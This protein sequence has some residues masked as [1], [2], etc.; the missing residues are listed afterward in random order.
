[1]SRRRPHPRAAWVAAAVLPVLTPG[2]LALATGEG[3]PT[4]TTP[5]SSPPVLVAEHTGT[6]RHIVPFGIATN[7][8]GRRTIWAFGRTRSA[9]TLDGTTPVAP[10]PTTPTQ[11]VL[12]QGTITTPGASTSWQRTTVPLDVTNTPLPPGSWR[13]ADGTATPP[14]GTT[15]EAADVMHS[16]QATPKGAAAFIA[17]VAPVSGTP[18]TPRSWPVRAMGD[19][20]SCPHRQ[21]NS[22]HPRPTR[23][24]ARLTTWRRWRSP[25]PTCRRA[26][27]R[28]TVAVPPCSSRRPAGMAC[29]AGMAC[30]GPRSHGSTPTVSRPGHGPL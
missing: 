13:P 30:G 1:M 25:M 19:S 5:P 7:A 17:R 11:A 26:T 8:D 22:S 15:P 28:R 3:D 2:A 14:V 4:S 24:R 20:E 18:R 23:S 6:A 21:P 16:G 29:C 12:L 9:S 27:S 10:D